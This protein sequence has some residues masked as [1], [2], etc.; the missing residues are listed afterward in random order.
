LSRIGDVAR[1]ALLTNR[2]S[3]ATTTLAYMLDQQAGG[4][5]ATRSNTAAIS[6]DGAF[7]NSVWWACLTL[8]ADVVSNFSVQVMKPEDNRKNAPLM[9]PVPAPPAFFSEP[10]TGIGVREFR[11]M[12]AMDRKRYGNFVGIIRARNSSDNALLVE[13]QSI[14]SCKAKMNGPKIQYWTINGQVYYPDE[15]WHE[16]DHLLAGFDLGLS[17]LGY[18]AQ[19]MGLYQSTQDF[20]QN[21]F[22]KGSNPRGVLKNVRRESV[23]AEV[24]KDAKAQFKESTADG[25]IF[26]V[27]TEWEWTPQATD[28]M[29]TA[30]LDQQEAS[31]RDVCRYLGVP[32]SMVDVEVST[33]NITYANVT[34]ANL[35][36]LI[37]KVGPAVGREEDYWTRQTGDAAWSVQFDTTNLLRMDPETLGNLQIAQAGAMLRVPSE[38]RVADGLAPYTDDQL[39]EVGFYAQLRR[40]A[41]APPGQNEDV[42]VDGGTAP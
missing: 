40:K 32:A 25:D 14:M 31:N 12:S 23:P 35:Q 41:P 27:G 11:Y 33:G 3:G 13:P 16:K 17:P 26:V 36:W 42:P 20:A 24:R 34:Q 22:A 1:S 10:F 4:S 5:R 2:A 28:S 7:R 29:S 9:V 37:T 38:L 39:E 19:T 8:W 18:A 6:L 30:F 21:W 15:I